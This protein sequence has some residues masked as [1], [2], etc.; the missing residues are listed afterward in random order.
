M[1]SPT[2]RWPAGGRR[3]SFSAFTE[4]SEAGFRERRTSVLC[5][6]FRVVY[7]A[8]FRCPFD[9][10]EENRLIHWEPPSAIAG[11]SVSHAANLIKL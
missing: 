6:K 8:G 9:T 2:L 10:R 7:A 5:L 3:R 11:R 4:I 1:L